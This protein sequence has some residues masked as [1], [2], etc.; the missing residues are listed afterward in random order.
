MEGFSGEQKT[1][2]WEVLGRHTAILISKVVACQEGKLIY[3]FGLAAS[4]AIH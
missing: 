2:R 4:N 3:C 1:M